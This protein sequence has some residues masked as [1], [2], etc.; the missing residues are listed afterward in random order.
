M[1]QWSLGEVEKKSFV[2]ILKGTATLGCFSYAAPPIALEK[3]FTIIK[4]RYC[5]SPLFLAL[6]TYDCFEHENSEHDV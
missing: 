2:R 6:A 3:I 1:E 4:M 5:F